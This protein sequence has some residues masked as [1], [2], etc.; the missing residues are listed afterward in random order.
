MKPGALFL[1]HDGALW[2]VCKRPR[3]QEAPTMA[4]NVDT[5]ALV[6]FESQNVA[7]RV[8]LS[9]GVYLAKYARSRAAAASRKVKL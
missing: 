2:L 5:G 4:A 8:R 1:D 7:K 9:L 6:L 3:W